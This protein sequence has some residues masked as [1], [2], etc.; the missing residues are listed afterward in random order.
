MSSRGAAWAVTTVPRKGFG[1][2]T[3]LSDPATHFFRPTHRRQSPTLSSTPVGPAR[4]RCPPATRGTKARFAGA[5]DSASTASTMFGQQRTGAV[6][7]VAEG[8][9]EP[10]LG[11]ANARDAG[12]QWSKRL[13]RVRASPQS[14]RQQRVLAVLQTVGDAGGRGIHERCGTSSRSRPPRRAAV[15]RRRGGRGRLPTVCRTEKVC[16]GMAGRVGG[17]WQNPALRV[18]GACDLSYGV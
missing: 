18:T 2:E 5:R 6:E 9:A 12:S 17:A 15:A 3:S 14:Q 16:G 7:A 10:G 8:D 11:L 13:R 1:T 4:P